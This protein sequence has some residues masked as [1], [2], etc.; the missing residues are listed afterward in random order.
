MTFSVFAAFVILACRAVEPRLG[1]DQTVTLTALV[2]RARLLA[3]FLLKGWE[4]REYS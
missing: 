1:Y 2:L 4:A 3:E